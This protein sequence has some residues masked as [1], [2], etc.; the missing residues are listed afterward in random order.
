MWGG[1]FYGKANLCAICA[2]FYEVTG[3]R[4]K[5]IINLETIF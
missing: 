5:K 3:Y 4:V 1:P 2:P